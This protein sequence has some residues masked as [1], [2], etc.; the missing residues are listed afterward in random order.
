MNRN[1]SRRPKAKPAKPSL[2]LA[3]A[4]HELALGKAKQEAE[5]R[6]LH[7]ESSK[8]E[9]EAAKLRTESKYMPWFGGL[10]AAAALV[11]A[12]ATLW[13]NWPF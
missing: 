8:M 7:A 4:D 10:G 6:K 1:V 12:A 5:L 3:R 11:G 13:K 2:P 9:A